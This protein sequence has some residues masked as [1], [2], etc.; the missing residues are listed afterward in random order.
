[1]HCLHRIYPNE[2]EVKDTTDTLTLTHVCFLPWPS[3]WNRQWRN[4]KNKTLWHSGDFAFPIVNFPLISSSITTIMEFTFHNSDVFLELVPSPAVFCTELSYW[5]KA[6]QNQATLLLGW[7]HH[8]KDSTVVT[9]IWLTVTKY[10][11]LKWQWIFYFLRTF[12]PLWLP[13][14]YQT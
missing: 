2:P 4:I 7:S 6:T 1:M 9:T 11:Y 5:R 12:F 8:Y 3:P 10:P 13:G 14:F